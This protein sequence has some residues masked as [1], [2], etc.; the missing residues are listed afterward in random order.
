LDSRKPV[1][2][3]SLG[4]KNQEIALEASQEIIAPYL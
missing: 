1:V 2:Y 4:K 3:N